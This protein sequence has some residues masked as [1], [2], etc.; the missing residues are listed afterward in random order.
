[1][2]QIRNS[3]EPFKSFKSVAH[4]LQG[5][6]LSLVCVWR[7]V[8]WKRPNRLQAAGR[9][10]LFNQTFSIIGIRFSLGTNSSVSVVGSR[11]MTR[12]RCCTQMND[13]EIW[14]RTTSGPTSF[15]QL[16]SRQLAGSDGWVYL[17]RRD[18]CVVPG[19][20]QV[21]QTI[22][23]LVQFVGLFQSHGLLIVTF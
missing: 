4:V 14:P 5:V 11:L 18:H 21:P 12:S 13:A 8:D 15:R 16:S 2:K 7:E 17:M 1:M 19:A 3:L 20:F 6:Y 9:V 10:D 23:N 22:M